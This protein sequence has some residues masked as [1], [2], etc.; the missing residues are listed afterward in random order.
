VSGTYR[1]ACD[2]LAFAGGEVVGLAGI[3]GGDPA[4][5]SP[6]AFADWQINWSAR[7]TRENW[8]GNVNGRFMASTEDIEAAP[9]NLENTADS[10]VYWDAQGYYSWDNVTV[11]AG[12]RNLTDEDPPYVTAYDDM[13]TLQYSYDTS[14]R[15]FYARVGIDF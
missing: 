9:A 15:Y 2:Y 8:G 12:V 3:F 1:D 13:N 10:I 7:L 6:A 14:G 4:C 11:T 5:G